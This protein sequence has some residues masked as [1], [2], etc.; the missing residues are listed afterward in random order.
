MQWLEGDLVS[1]VTLLDI[2]RDFCCSLGDRAQS[3]VMILPAKNR[4][5][6]V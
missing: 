4:K 1:E 5:R 6:V 3:R 2:S